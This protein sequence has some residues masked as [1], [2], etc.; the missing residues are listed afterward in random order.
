MSVRQGTNIIAS[1]GIVN[2]HDDSITGTGLI[3]DPLSI[4]QSLL[5]KINISQ[6]VTNAG[7]ILQV[8]P[9]GNV[10]LRDLTMLGPKVYVVNGMILNSSTDTIQG[11]GR[12]IVSL[13]PS[14]MARVDFCCKITVAGSANTFNWGINRDQ[15]H[16][17]NSAIPVITPKQGVCTYLNVSGFDGLNGNSGTLEAISQFWQPGRIYQNSGD[18]GGWPSNQ[19]GVDAY[20]T[21]TAYGTYTA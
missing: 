18:F 15:L 11:V 12:A 9:T 7:K 21:G 10:E 14:G 1:G 13:Y 6:G 20:I 4:K 3:D 17:L 8:G 19:F 16:L 5:K 2:Y